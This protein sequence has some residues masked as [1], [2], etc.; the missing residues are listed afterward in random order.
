MKKVL[1][2][3]LCAVMLA[4]MVTGCGSSTA[5]ETTAAQTETKT[6]Q[7]TVAAVAATEAAVEEEEVPEE[8]VWITLTDF[9]PTLE[10]IVA[11]YKTGTVRF[12][13]AIHSIDK[14]VHPIKIK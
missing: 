6:E 9:I 8:I 3:A 10:P 7:T 13:D 4:T 14:K 5:Q 11:R 12:V 2:L 1:A